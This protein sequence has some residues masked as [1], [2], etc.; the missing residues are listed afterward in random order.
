MKKAMIKPVRLQ[1][2]DAIAAFAPASLFEKKKAK[3]GKLYLKKNHKIEVLETKKPFLKNHFIARTDA[4]RISEFNNWVKNKSIKGMIAYRGGYGTSRIIQKLDIKALKNNP[5]LVIGYS[6]LTIL[7]NELVKNGLCCVHG[8]MLSGDFFRRSHTELEQRSFQSCF[9]TGIP[10]GKVGKKE[11]LKCF[12]P[13]T[14][15]GI[16]TGGN[17][18]TLASSIGTPYEFDSKGKIL[19]LEDVGEKPYRIDRLLVQLKDAGKFDKC[20]GIIFGDFTDCDQAQRPK[21]KSVIQEALSGINIPVIWGFPS[22]HGKRQ[23]FLPF[24][25]KVKIDSNPLL[26]VVDFLESCVS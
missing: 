25:T 3:E 10:I 11:G 1:S 16:L 2:G 23:C 4:E 7:L 12:V 20:K 22:G 15:K 6:D 19:F 18:C 21:I 13:G 14:A 24:G 9:F 5:K 26:P 8:P 17:L